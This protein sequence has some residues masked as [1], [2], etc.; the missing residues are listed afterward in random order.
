MSELTKVRMQ[1]LDAETDEVLEEVDVLSSASSILFPDGINLEEKIDQI[2]K[3]EGPQG[4][5][6][7]IGATGPQGPKGDTGA[8][9]ATGAT[10][11]QGAK[12]DTGQRGSNWYQ[13]T[14][15]TGTST[16]ETVFSGSG[17]A[18]ALVNDKYLNT[19][20]GAVY[21]CTIAGAASVAKWVYI[22]SIKGPTGIQGPKGD[23]GAT[24]PKGDTGAI[25]PQG[26]KG[27][28]GA[29]G[30]KGATG[31]TG[32]QGPKG[33][34]G[35]TGQ[36]G[37]NWYQGT[38]ITGTSTTAAVFS[39]SGIAAALVNDKYLNTSTGAV[40]NCTVAGAASVAKWAYAGSIKGPTGAQGPKGDTG[41]V[42]AQGPKGDTGATGARGATGA[43]GPQGIQG[44][45]GPKG[46]DGD[47]LKY[48]TSYATASEIKVFLKKL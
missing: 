18:A 43:Q 21:N 37:S 20:T 35:A 7:D 29:A 8:K 30:A 46:A 9:G 26:P 45:Q 42:G 22:G 27:D 19:S 39:N 5:K 44:P 10:G 47:K 25:G 14:A 41:A 40:Y 11:P 17:I 2:E 13:G 36:R 38:A 4:P 1:I 34:T 33:D 15:I 31:A 28:T 23:M 12:G 32:P 3:M 24:G 16:T 48:G 6:G